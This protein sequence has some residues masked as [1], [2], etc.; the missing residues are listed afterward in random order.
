M[1]LAHLSLFSGV[2]SVVSIS[3]STVQASPRSARSNTIRTVRL[4]SNATGPMCPDGAIYERWTL[5]TF[6]PSMF[7]AEDSPAKT[8]LSRVGVLDSLVKGLA[9]GGSSAESS[10][11]G[12]PDGWSSRTSLDSCHQTGDGIWEPSSGSWRTMGMGSRTACWTLNGSEFPSDVAV[13]SLSDIL[14]A[15]VP[16]KYSL[17]ARA[18]SGILRRAEKRGRSL[19]PLL[20]TALVSVA[21]GQTTTPPKPTT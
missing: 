2:L 19:P 9:C 20:A 5:M 16:A 12:F 11:L 21:E 17:S 18:A 13:C 8:S 7:S 3:G 4:F 15:T 14:E 1:S 6:Q 10:L